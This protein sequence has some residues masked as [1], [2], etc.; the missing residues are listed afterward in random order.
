MCEGVL[1][2][3]KMNIFCKMTK[4]EKLK[5][6]DECVKKKLSDNDG[7]EK[8]PSFTVNLS[9]WSKLDVNFFWG[10]AGRGRGMC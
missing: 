10:V 5:Y 2:W 3:G 7:C 8:T 6:N 4:K 9:S 1:G